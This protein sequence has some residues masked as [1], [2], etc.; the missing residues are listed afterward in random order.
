MKKIDQIREH[1]DLVT[2]KEQSDIDK[3]TALVRAGLFDSKKLPLLKRAMEKNPADLTLAERKI[4]L[5]LLDA[6][7]S[8][9]LHSGQ[10]YNK[11]KTNVRQVNEASS[12]EVKRDYLTKLDTRQDKQFKERDMPYIIVLKR[13]GIRYFTDT[14]KVGLYYSQQLDRYF[15]I[16]FTHNKGGHFAVGSGNDMLEE[17]VNTKKDDEEKNKKDGVKRALDAMEKRRQS[18]QKIR[19][20]AAKKDI[21]DLSDNKRKYVR[22]LAMKKAFD[23]GGQNAPEAIGFAIGSMFAKK[24]AKP[25]AETEKKALPKPDAKKQIGHDKIIDGE[26]TD[27][28]SKKVDGGSK[29][30]LPKSEPKAVEKKAE[31][32]RLTGPGSKIRESF[33]SRLSDKRVNEGVVG[34]AIKKI[35]QKVKSKAASMLDG[36]DSSGGSSGGS[37]GSKSV[38][39]KIQNSDIDSKLKVNISDPRQQKADTS[40]ALSKQTDTLYRKSLKENFKNKLAEAREYGAADAAADAASFIPGPAG[41]AASLAS[42]GLSLSRGDYVGAALDAAGALPLVGYAAKAAKVAKAGKGG[43]AAKAADKAADAEKAAEKAKDAEKA[44]EK[45]KEVAKSETKAEK[46]AETGKEVEKAESKA[47]EK[48]E[49][50]ADKVEKAEKAETKAD[51]VEKA[52]KAGKE[53]KTVSRGSRAAKWLG[54]GALGAAALGAL[55]GGSGNSS[56]SDNSDDDSK[57]QNSDINSKLKATVVKPDAVDTSDAQRKQTDTMYRKSLKSMKED[58]RGQLEN[59]LKENV[60]ESVISVDG[61]PITINTTIANKILSVYESV[62]KSNKT[63]ID[64]MLNESVDSFKKIVSFAV[65]Q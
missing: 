28:T 51:K 4:M 34:D 24:K 16:P 30:V 52:A 19:K 37:S 40:A 29:K 10:V 46:A 17:A 35:T 62:N 21:S 9:V 26:F 31:P 14:Q 18:K 44:S 15:S 25:E 1:Y 7:M 50:K 64:H 58:V 12:A 65:R 2:E 38:E 55:S 53:A 20:L 22:N 59:F 43:K 56:S 3:L 33:R 60:E 57:Y 45:G 39:R 48:A 32:L 42:A 6:L 36:S 13:K 54:R 41:S 47:V 23:N 8:E 63:K 11:V 5:E 27:V 49:T 61:N